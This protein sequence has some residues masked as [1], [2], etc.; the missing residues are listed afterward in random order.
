MVMR[1]AVLPYYGFVLR[2]LLWAAVLAAVARPTLGAEQP[3]HAAGQPS[4]DVAV[5]VWPAYSDAPELRWAFPE[6]MGEWERVRQARPKFPGHELPGIPLWGYVNEADPYVMEMQIR[7]AA[8]HGIR[9]FI[10]DW[11]WY[12]G[13]PFLEQCLTQGFLKARNCGDVKFYLMWANH[14]V[15]YAWDIRN[16]WDRTT[17]LYRGGVDRAEF[18]RVA[19]YVLTRYFTHP[20]YYRI[21]G[22]PVFSIYDLA[23]LVRGLGG[24]KPAAAA[25]AWFREEA[26]RAGLPGL[27]LQCILRGSRFNLSGV[28]DT[29]A[30]ISQAEAIQALGFDSLT[31]YQFCHFLNVRNPLS[32]VVEMAEREWRNIERTYG[33]PYF[34]HVSVGWDNNARFV[35]LQPAIMT[36][37]GPPELAAALRRAR[38]WADAHPGQPPLITINAWNEWTEGSYL[39]PC[40]RHGYGYLQAVR[41]AF[42]PDAT[43]TSAVPARP[44]A[45]AAS[46]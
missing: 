4:Y 35:E 21:G 39:Q 29:A 26:V 34:A 36:S 7:A 28:D 12:D 13:R 3:Q 33:I 23:N 14:D 11:Y 8:D 30:T 43:S 44:P 15:K 2:I 17:V 20:A 31:H 24:L 18:E 40:T 19:R 10:Y 9:I 45:P 46:P 5:Y 32:N 6:R 25:L 27:H 16:S 42:G 37:N 1:K 41:E 38:A 22:R